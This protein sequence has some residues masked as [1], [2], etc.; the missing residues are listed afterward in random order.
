M[1]QSYQ[2]NNNIY[3]QNTSSN[4]NN[5][6]LSFITEDSFQDNNDMEQIG[7]VY[8]SVSRMSEEASDVE[9]IKNEPLPMSFQSDISHLFRSDQVEF[10]QDIPMNL[11]KTV[12]VTSG[13]ENNFAPRDRVLDQDSYD[14]GEKKK[15]R[16]KDRFNKFQ[17][18]FGVSD[19]T[20]FREKFE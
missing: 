16:K 5:N 10:D 13:F 9:G 14:K 6:I 4:G 8:D 17:R 11:N 12:K 20:E 15:K 1:S 3:G 7:N 18:T 2:Y 19:F